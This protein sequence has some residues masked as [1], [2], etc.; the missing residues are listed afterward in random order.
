MLPLFLAS[1]VGVLALSLPGAAPAHAGRAQERPAPD[2]IDLRPFFRRWG[3]ETRRQ[4]P[5]GTCSVFTV[6]GA[7]EYAAAR[8]QGRGTRL[9]VEFLNWAAHKAVNRTADGGFF[10][11]LWKGYADYGVCPEDGLPYRERYDAGL[12]PEPAVLARARE[13]RALG[14][15]MNWIKEWDV[16]TGLM[17][18]Q[19]EAIQHTLARG[20]P[21]CGGFR[22][23]KREQW[24]GEVLRMCPPEE[25]FDGHSVLLIGYKE[26]PN[27]LGGGAFLIRNSG[28]DGRDGC[29]PYEYVRAYMNDALWISDGN[30]PRRHRDTE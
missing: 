13:M 29:L 25:V 14:L 16:K 23:P 10:S 8:K 1:L 26:D 19:F 7:L 27:Q 12:Q 15:R 5:R 17:R 9:S 6:V 3:L 24:D 28:G 22:W 4:G 18:P 21:I 11:E 20:W 2:A 30:S